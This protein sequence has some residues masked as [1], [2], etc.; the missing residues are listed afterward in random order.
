MAKWQLNRGELV[1]LFGR[2]AACE[3]ERGAPCARASHALR[4]CPCT[5]STRDEWMRD[6]PNG[7]LTANTIYNG[8]GESLRNVVQNPKLDLYIITTKQARRAT[9]CS[10]S[11]AT[12]CLL[13]LMRLM[14]QLRRALRTG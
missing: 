4:P 8:V 14:R 1:E 13:L 7:W 3:C 12:R 11:R 10:A 5:R 6:D 9:A 2:R